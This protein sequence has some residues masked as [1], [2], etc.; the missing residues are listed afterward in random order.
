[1]KLERCV[2]IKKSSPSPHG[3]GKRGEAIRRQ[4]RFPAVGGERYICVCQG[5]TIDLDAAG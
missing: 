1:M 4:S 5:E 3:I 2:Q